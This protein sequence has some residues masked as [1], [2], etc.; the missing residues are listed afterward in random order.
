MLAEPC[1]RITCVTGECF[2]GICMCPTGIRGM[3]CGECVQAGQVLDLQ[4]QTCVPETPTN[5]T[6]LCTVG[7]AYCVGDPHCVTLDGSRFDFM[8]QCE[9]TL[10]HTFC[11]SRPETTVQVRQSA[12]PAADGVVAVLNGVA[13]RESSSNGS[14][15]VV[16]ILA[17]AGQAGLN[18]SVD[19]VAFAGRGTSLSLGNGFGVMQ[20]SS[21]ATTVVVQLGSGLVVRAEWSTSNGYT[22]VINLYLDALEPSS[23]CGCTE[24]LLGFADGSLGKE[25]LLPLAGYRRS[26]DLPVQALSE[27]AS[28]PTPEVPSSLVFG[29]LWRLRGA[30]HNASQRLFSGAEPAACSAAPSPSPSPPSPPLPPVNCSS[31]AAARTCCANATTS[32]AYMDCIIDFC[33]TDSCKFVYPP[34]QRKC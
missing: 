15:P 6:D 8:G 1:D 32:A 19:G 34:V 10:L 29:E 21:S 24:G 23:V 27:F 20:V 17:L 11:A 4:S 9:Y 22:G 7:Q 3:L 2:R 12:W 26:S 16:E 5:T 14:S 13:V 30:A 31:S 25:F 18:I 28:I 33:A